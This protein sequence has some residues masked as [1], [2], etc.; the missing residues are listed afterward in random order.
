MLGNIVMWAALVFIG[1]HLEISSTPLRGM[2]A[3]VLGER[4][5]LGFYSLV[6]LASLGFL[7][8]A[9]G[10]SPHTT[11]VYGPSG[12]LNWIPVVVTPFAL[13]LVVGGV[14]VRNPS[15][16][17]QDQSV[18]DPNVAQGFLRI[19]RHPIQIGILLWSLAHVAANG[20][21]ASLWF[22]GSLGFVSAMGRW[23]IERKKARMLGDDWQRFV[24][25]TSVIPLVAI[26]AGRNRLALSEIWI[27]ILVGLALW[28]A[29]LWGHR[30]ISGVPVTL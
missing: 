26:A 18:H 15:A 16:V 5:Y 25:D 29:L 3:G 4:G 19:T 11:F 6:A 2:L 22:F 27:P 24:A 20:D 12:A 10:A 7:I 14:M 8:Y 28:I 23:L 30:W 9:Y 1:T 21:V 17:M 13:M